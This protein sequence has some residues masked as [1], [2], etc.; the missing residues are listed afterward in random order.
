[1]S[2]RP[3]ERCRYAAKS[4]NNHE[5]HKDGIHRYRFSVYEWAHRTPYAR[6]PTEY[7]ACKTGRRLSTIDHLTFLSFGLAGI[8]Y[9]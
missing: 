6:V 9:T 1:L 7:L 5:E 2:C 4:K 3:S 8:V